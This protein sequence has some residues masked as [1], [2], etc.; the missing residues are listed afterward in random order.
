MQGMLLYAMEI[1]IAAMAIFWSIKK[2]RYL[3]R[4]R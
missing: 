3:L 2:R 1:M 4:K